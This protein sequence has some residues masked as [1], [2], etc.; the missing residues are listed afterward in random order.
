MMLKKFNIF[1]YV[2]IFSFLL[3][4]YVK[5]VHAEE[6]IFTETSNIPTGVIPMEF[7][8]EDE[9]KNYISQMLLDEV[10]IEDDCINIDFRGTDRTVTVATKR[11]GVAGKIHLKLSYGTSLP[12]NKGTIEYADAFT[13]TSGFSLGFNWVEDNIGTDIRPSGKDIYVYASGRIE[14]YILVNGVTKFY[15]R[16][17]DLHGTVSAVR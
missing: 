13:T 11:L 17:I 1:L 5:D 4:A 2:V 3:L 7:N 14:Y 8:T 15:E 10:Y 12:G 9:A 6:I 16:D